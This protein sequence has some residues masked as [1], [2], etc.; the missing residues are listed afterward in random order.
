[1]LKQYLKEND[2]TNT[3]YK[4][5][6][7]FSFVNHKNEEIVM[8]WGYPSLDVILDGGIVKSSY[9]VFYSG[10]NAGKSTA[11][12]IHLIVQAIRNGKIPLIVSLEGSWEEVVT[13]VCLTL[14]GKAK[15]GLSFLSDTEKQELDEILKTVKSLPIIHT[16]ASKKWELESLINTYSPDF[17]I[18]D[19]L[20]LASESK[21][22]DDMAKMSQTLQKISLETEIPV[23]AITQSDDINGEALLNNQYNDEVDLKKETRKGKANIKYS[24]SIYQDARNVIYLRPSTNKIGDKYY[25]RNNFRF[26]EITKC[27]DKKSQQFLGG[28]ILIEYTNNGMKEHGY[29][30]LSENYK[31]EIISDTK[32]KLIKNE[33]SIH[34]Q[35]IDDI[36]KVDVVLPSISQKTEK[37]EQNND[38]EKP[39]KKI[40]ETYSF[41]NIEE[42]FSQKII[43]DIPNR[44]KQVSEAFD[45][46][47]LSKT[48]DLIDNL[49]TLDT[50]FI[51][52]YE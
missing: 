3:K 13:D 27:K 17:I 42:P 43:N 9:S 49:P 28:R 41:P 50:N 1:M 47:E 21:S 2:T 30:W 35:K 22:W 37:I 45:I 10:S 52:F 19:Q 15:E 16:G 6:G 40:S 31:E 23:V 24:A 48:A 7:D 34:T 5:F 14:Y 29:V 25:N 26:L 51:D 8:S 4:T 18:Y 46:P 38:L 36:E 33:N 12:K 20:T 44:L 39:P 32:L 11:I